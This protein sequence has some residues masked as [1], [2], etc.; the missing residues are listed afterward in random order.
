MITT[1]RTSGNPRPMPWARDCGKALIAGRVGHRRGGAVDQHDRT[2]V[3]EPVGAAAVVGLP[4]RLADQP[5]DDSQGEP[6]PRI[7]VGAGVLG[8]RLAAVERH[9]DDHASDRGAAGV[10]GIQ[11]LGEERAQGHEW[12]E[13]RV[14]VTDALRREGLPDHGLVEDFLEGEAHGIVEGMDRLEDRSSCRLGHGRS[15]G[16]DRTRVVK[17][18]RVVPREAAPCLS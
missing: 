16:R 18:P 3:P 15:P 10:V 17:L 9:P 6:T 14:V 12:G 11:D 1:N 2:P 7:A 5:D 4:R 8:A 13:D